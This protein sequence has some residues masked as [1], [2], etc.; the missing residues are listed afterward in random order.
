[1]WGADEERFH[2]DCTQQVNTDREEKLGIWE[3]ISAQGPT[4]ARIYD[5]NMDGQ[6][7]CD[8][9]SGKLK[10]SMAKLH[11]KDKIIYQ[12]NLAPWHISHMVKAKMK[13]I[14]LK[15]LDWFA[16]NTDLNPIELVWSILDKKLMTAL[17]CNKATLCKR[18]EE[19]WIGHGIELCRRL[20]DSMPGRL[21]KC[22]L[23]EGGHF[24]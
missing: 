7:Y 24:N 16:K 18:L 6:M 2:P 12:Q 4:E 13:K 5:E 10:R 15:V 17:I 19:T 22:L 8:I 1:M 11:D 23:E 21:K 9:L 14:K 20:V 3:S